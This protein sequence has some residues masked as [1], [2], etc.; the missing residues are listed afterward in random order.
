MV[1]NGNSLRKDEETG[2]LEP[3]LNYSLTGFNAQTK[4]LVVHFLREDYNISK[5]CESV[6]INPRNFYHHLRLDEAFR[7]AVDQAREH[8]LDELESTMFRNAKTEK[9]TADRIFALK[10][11]RRERYGERTTIEHGRKD[12][13]DQLFERLQESGKIINIESADY[14]V[15]PQSS[16]NTPT[17][18]TP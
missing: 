17:N 2:F 7:L 3:S 9:G 14:S 16:D 18:T 1:L 10:S 12:S 11:W 4:S 6:G 13:A 5:A 8:H 15:T